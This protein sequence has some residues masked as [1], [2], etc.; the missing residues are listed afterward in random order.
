[1]EIVSLLQSHC[2]STSLSSLHMCWPTVGAASQANLM[3]ISLYTAS[4]SFF[5]IH[6]FNK[7]F[8]II[9]YLL[10]SVRDPGEKKMK[11][12]FLMKLMVK[13]EFLLPF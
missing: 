12:P 2:G 1:M 11:S 13:H 8:P 9:N 10:Y 4:H 3:P 6:P 7:I 5:F